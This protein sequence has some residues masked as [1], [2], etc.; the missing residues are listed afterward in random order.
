MNEMRELA[1][2]LRRTA[3]MLDELAGITKHNETPKTAKK[4]LRK[5]KSAKKIPWQHRPGNEAKAEK[6]RKN[7][8]K[9]NKAKRK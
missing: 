9:I 5:T 4:I 1:A 3:D 6:W 7:I 8:M 2:K